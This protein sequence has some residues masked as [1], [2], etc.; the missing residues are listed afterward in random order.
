MIF[1]FMCQ[2]R[3]HQLFNFFKNS[4]IFELINSLTKQNKSI[5]SKYIKLLYTPQY[6]PILFDI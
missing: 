1:Y 6:L 3:T 5:A 4:I 2:Y